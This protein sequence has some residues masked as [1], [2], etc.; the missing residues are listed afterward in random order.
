MKKGAGVYSLLN[1]LLTS[2]NWGSLNRVSGVQ[3]FVCKHIMNA[4][5][6]P[7]DLHVAKTSE[8]FKSLR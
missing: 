4:P 7:M 8:I 1:R 6:N 3:S 2:L 5:N